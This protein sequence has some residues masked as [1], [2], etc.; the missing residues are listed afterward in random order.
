MKLGC[1]LRTNRTMR[2][3]EKQEK[4]TVFQEALDGGPGAIKHL[5][6]TLERATLK[7]ALP[8]GTHAGDKP[9]VSLLPRFYD[10]GNFSL[11]LSSRAIPTMSQRTQNSG[12]ASL[13]V[14]PTK[15]EFAAR[16]PLR[17]S[18]V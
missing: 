6:T 9:E 4:R 15:V 16:A 13:G 17:R 10:P 14:A 18:K 2:P 11:L 7:R 3:L 8:T 5:R 12:E 1:T